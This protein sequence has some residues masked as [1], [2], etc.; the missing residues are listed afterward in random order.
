MLEK[1]S[2]VSAVANSCAPIGCRRASRAASRAYHDIAL[3][4]ALMQSVIMVGGQARHNQL[5]S[6]VTAV[7]SF[8]GTVLLRAHDL[9]QLSLTTR[10]PAYVT[11]GQTGKK[12]Q[13]S[14]CEC[15]RPRSHV[16]RCALT[17]GACGVRHTAAAEL[18]CFKLR[19]AVHRSACARL[20]LVLSRAAAYRIQAQEANFKATVEALEARVKTVEEVNASAAAQL[21]LQGAPAQTV[22]RSL[23][24]RGARLQPYGTIV[25]AWHLHAPCMLQRITSKRRVKRP[26]R[27]QTVRGG[28]MGPAPLLPAFE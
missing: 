18:S 5:S 1:P 21:Q 2:G 15:S 27:S 13:Q 11:R 28:A 14:P 16:R 20:A 9:K 23:R 12:V 22:W 6:T 25:R 26:R 24:S 8:T 7:E 3:G 4:R 19:A 17:S 10:Q